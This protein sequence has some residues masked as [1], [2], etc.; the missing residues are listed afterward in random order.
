MGYYDDHTNTE[1]SN[2]KSGSKA[3]YFFSSLVGVIVGALIV[4]LAFPMFD[5]GNNS[6][7]SNSGTAGQATESQPI[8]YDV[9]SDVTAAVEKAGD[10]V[11]GVTN[12]QAGGGMFGQQSEAQEAGTGSGVIYK[13]EGDSAFI[14][15]NYHVIEGSDQVEVTL[16]DGTKEEATVL[17]G[18]QWTDLAVLQISGENVETVAEFGDS[19]ALKPGEPVIAIGNPLG[20]QFSGSVTTGVVSG[21]ERTIPV[22][23][24]QDG[25][26]DWQAEVIQTDA[27]INPGNSGGA[28]VNSQGQLIGINSMKIAQSSVEGIGLA[29]PIDMAQP[30]IND[31]ESKGEVDRP[32]MGITLFDLANVPAV[33]Q[34]EQ[35]NLPEEVTTGVVIERVVPNSAAANA[36]LEDMDVIVEM[37]GEKINN[38][39]EL[40]QHLYTEKS[41]GDE[42]QVK[43]YRNGEMVEV[44]MT[45]T[46]DSQL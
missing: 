33:Y 17:G 12:L 16:A 8:S 25:Q 42:M 13:E 27:A 28:L 6:T 19:Q 21:V 29:I 5:G 23:I 39:M 24:N 4:A 1:R 44:T 34:Q 45:L 22:D 9:S 14:V 20:L 46:D 41:V 15:T 3:G 43:V 18:D 38:S 11:V 37:D 7:V 26:V 10:A 2:K 36:G 32:T 30:I 31:L 40:R 35:L